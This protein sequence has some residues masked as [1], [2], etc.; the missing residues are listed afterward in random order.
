VVHEYV[1][2]LHAHSFYSDGWA[3]HET[4]ALE[5]LRAGLDLVVVTDHNVYVEGFDGYRYGDG[6]RVLLLTG[7]EI[8]DQARRPQKNHLLVFEARRELAQLAHDP[9]RL[10]SAVEQL[11]GLSFLAHPVDP[12][13]PVAN[14]PDLSWADWDVRGYT[15]L[16]LWNSMTEFK[17][18]LRS[19]LDALLYAFRPASITRSPFPAALERWDRLLGAGLRVVAIGGAD[20]HA[21]TGRLGPIRRTIF[22]Y[23]FL[24]RGVNTHVLTDEPLSGDEAS[25]RQRLFHS[26]GRGRCFVGYDRPASTLGFRFTAQGQGTSATMGESLPVGAGVTLQISLPRR[27]HLRLLRNGDSIDGWRSVTGAVRVVNVPGAYRVEAHLPYRAALRGWIYSNPIY[28][29]S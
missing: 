28:V 14:Q 18:L 4:I 25:D 9:Q 21:F 15:G 13:S 23:S 5:A 7:E 17:S 12:A 6:R 2:N 29:T 1:A 24:F 20:A 11:G 10:L 22:P 26:L 8:H 16:E 19:R 3:D 27:A